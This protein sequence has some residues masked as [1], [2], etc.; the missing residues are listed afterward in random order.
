MIVDK[1]TD[2]ARLSRAC[3]RGGGAQVFA[4]EREK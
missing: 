3:N 4:D 2:V 1:R